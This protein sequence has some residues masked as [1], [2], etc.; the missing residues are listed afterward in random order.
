ML[1]AKTWWHGESAL[2]QK[3]KGRGDHQLRS[4]NVALLLKH[5]VKFY[6]RRDIPWVNLIWDTYY[7]NEELPHVLGDKGS[8]WWRDPLKLYDIYRGIA[9]CTIGNGSTI[10]FW[11]DIWNEQFLQQK[12][13]RLYSYAK[14]NKNT[15]VAQ[16]L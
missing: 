5:L 3:R 6:N 2:D 12:H 4:Q 8:F 14:K 1:K 7:P 13:P 15:L 9:Q 11:L 10:M 16:F